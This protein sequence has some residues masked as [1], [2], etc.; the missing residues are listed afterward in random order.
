MSDNKHK[1]VCDYCEVGMF[2]LP[3]IVFQKNVL[4]DDQLNAMDEW[5]KEHNCGTRMTDRLW[6]FTSTAKR[7]WFLFRWSAELNVK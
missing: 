6:S 2:R 1:D 4:T 5:C 3:G 7:D